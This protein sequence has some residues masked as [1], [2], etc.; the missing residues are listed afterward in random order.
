MSSDPEFLALLRAA[1]RRDAAAEARLFSLVYDELRRVAR[2]QRLRWG[3]A[4]T[5]NTTALVHEGYLRLT[6]GAFS[7][8]EDRRH[9]VN[10]AGRVMRSVVVDAARRRATAKRGGDSEHADVA[11]RLDEIPD[12]IFERAP[13]ELLALDA[14]LDR[15]NAADDRLARV[16]EMKFFVGLSDEETADALGVTGRTV[17]R[18]WRRARAFLL[19]ELGSSPGLAAANA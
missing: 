19:V 9:F 18:D 4:P 1:G 11:E 12:V 3:A 10:L 15:L 2:S 14:A 5:L 16:V 13:E 7:S 8:V 17:R 6:R